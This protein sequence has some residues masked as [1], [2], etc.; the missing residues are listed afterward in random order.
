M[1]SL[2]SSGKREL[3]VNEMGKLGE[4]TCFLN[5]MFL[6]FPLYQEKENF[7]WGYKLCYLQKEAIQR[8]YWK[9]LLQ[10]FRKAQVLT[11][12]F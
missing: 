9:W 5:T 2:D 8:H 1:T 3:V 12:P 4:L 11:L 6:K 7:L 10:K